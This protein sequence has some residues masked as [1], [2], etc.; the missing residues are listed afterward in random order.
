[1][2]KINPISHK[3]IVCENINHKMYTFGFLMFNVNYYYVS[4]FRKSSN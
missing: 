4:W 2:C 1:M 3:N